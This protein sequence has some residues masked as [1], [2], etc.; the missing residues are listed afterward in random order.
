MKSG[1]GSSEDEH[2]CEYVVFVCVCV[3]L[4]GHQKRKRSTITN[5]EV[6]CPRGG[7]SRNFYP[8]RWPVGHVKN[9][10]LLLGEHFQKY[11]KIYWNCL[12]K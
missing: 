11:A 12:P 4:K 2:T 3:N 8:D 9:L 1:P 7:L 6:A 10:T 5:P